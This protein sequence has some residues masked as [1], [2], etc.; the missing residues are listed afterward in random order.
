MAGTDERAQTRQQEGLCL[1]RA[2]RSEDAGAERVP[3]AS[4]HKAER[5]QAVE[6]GVGDALDEAGAVHRRELPQCRNLRSEGG[7]KI[8]CFEPVRT[9]SSLRVKV[10]MSCLRTAG[11]KDLRAEVF[12][13]EAGGNRF[14]WP[15]EGRTG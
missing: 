13:R 11:A 9:K 15:S 2:G 6:P 8:R 14:G 4:I 7:K 1:V 5:G 3:T 12:I 10:S